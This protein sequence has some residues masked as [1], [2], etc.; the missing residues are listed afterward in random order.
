M[1]KNGNKKNKTKKNNIRSNV[2]SNK[3]KRPLRPLKSQVGKKKSGEEIIG[4]Y[5]AVSKNYGFVRT[6]IDYNNEEY[7]SYSFL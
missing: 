3:P 2:K 4:I 5:E 1:K 6:L 7:S